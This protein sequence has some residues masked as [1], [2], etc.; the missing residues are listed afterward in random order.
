METHSLPRG[1][2]SVS[3]VFFS[4]DLCVVHFPSVWTSIA[5]R[6]GRC[7]LIGLRN[8][9]L[10][11]SLPMAGELELDDLYVPP[12]QTILW[13]SEKSVLMLWLCFRSAGYPLERQQA[14]PIRCVTLFNSSIVTPFSNL[15]SRLT[16]GS[17][18]SCKA[19]GGRTWQ[20]L[21]LSVQGP[22]ESCLPAAPGSVVLWS[23][24]RRPKKSCFFDY[25]FRNNKALFV[26]FCSIDLHKLPT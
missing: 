1:M 17:K 5:L 4:T 13:F 15:P 22:K 14:G 8:T 11:V 10:S 3:V 12:T 19:L 26:L 20:L 25:F 7:F 2:L 6:L 16:L 9:F 23:S 21:L 24:I 18:D